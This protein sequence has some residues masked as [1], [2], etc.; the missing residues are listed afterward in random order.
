[1]TDREGKIAVSEV[2]NRWIDEAMARNFGDGH[3]DGLVLNTSPAD[4]T[5]HHL[6]SLALKLFCCRLLAL[7]LNPSGILTPNCTSWQKHQ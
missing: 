3:E 4:L 1:V 5:F 7:S 6:Q 2:S